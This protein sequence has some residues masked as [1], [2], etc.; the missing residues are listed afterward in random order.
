MLDMV[1]DSLG[2]LGPVDDSAA[3]AI[4]ILDV[5]HSNQEA[6]ATAA[7][8]HV[9][10]SCFSWDRSFERLFS[11]VYPRALERRPSAA[12][13]PRADAYAESVA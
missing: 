4:N 11:D 8:A 6:M 3:M 2:R 12:E 1:D 5:W 10:A 7:R 13:R 9:E